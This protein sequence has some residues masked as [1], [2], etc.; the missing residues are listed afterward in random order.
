MVGEFSE[1]R[2][3]FQATQTEY[4]VLPSHLFND[5]FTTGDFPGF[6]GRGGIFMMRPDQIRA[7]EQFADQIRN[8]RDIPVK[9]GSGNVTYTTGGFNAPWLE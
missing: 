6:K 2:L 4:G 8:K 7:F 1:R 5:V 3:P 9:D